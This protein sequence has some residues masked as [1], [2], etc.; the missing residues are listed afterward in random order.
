M[1]DNWTSALCVIGLPADAVPLILHHEGREALRVDRDGSLT[2]NT[3]LLRE[4]A[5]RVVERSDAPSMLPEDR[6]A[7]N[8]GEVPAG[9]APDS[10]NPHA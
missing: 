3:E 2:Y 6:T 1:S 4:W 10:G 9:G 8:A 5:R 7:R